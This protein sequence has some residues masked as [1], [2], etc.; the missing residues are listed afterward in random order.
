MEIDETCI[1]KELHSKHIKEA[2]KLVDINNTLFDLLLKK[3]NFTTIDYYIA[4]N[5]YIDLT[6]KLL[7]R[8]RKYCLICHI[9]EML[10]HIL[11]LKRKKREN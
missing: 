1:Y 4:V 11:K 6:K 8:L 3:L 9:L 10:L 7:K 2:Q 5:K